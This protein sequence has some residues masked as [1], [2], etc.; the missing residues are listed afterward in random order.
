MSNDNNFGKKLKQ[1]RLARGLSQARLAE[2]ADLHEKH[3]S[4][5]ET[6]RFHPN[7]E[8]LNKILRALNLKLDDICLDLENVST[9]DNPLFLKSIQI[10]NDAD[11]Q[12]LEFYYTLLKTAQKGSDIFKNK[13]KEV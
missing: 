13:F 12:E 11:E 9:N 5:I 3:I 2:M 6:G 7:F 10:L 8:T 4:K 1:I